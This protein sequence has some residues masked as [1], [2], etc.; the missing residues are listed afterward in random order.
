MSFNLNQ[1]QSPPTSSY[2]TSPTYTEA[3]NDSQLVR[4][5]YKKAK[6]YDGSGLIGSL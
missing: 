6:K 2:Y 5:F 1:P 4:I 3:V